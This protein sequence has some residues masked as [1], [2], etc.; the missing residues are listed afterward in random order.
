MGSSSGSVSAAEVNRKM[1]S[2]GTASSGSASSGGASS[3]SA[4]NNRLELSHQINTNSR[5]IYGSICYAAA[6]VFGSSNSNNT[7]LPA[8]AEGSGA[9]STD[10]HAVSFPAAGAEIAASLG[11]SS[12]S[13]CCKPR[14]STAAVYKAAGGSNSRRQQQ[15]EA[16]TAGGSSSRRQLWYARCASAPSKALTSCTEAPAG[17]SAAT[18]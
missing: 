7:T 5:S 17:E 18:L 9:R 15:P 1:R 2:S 3:N 16:A 12:T 13:R 14:D 8:A 4:G 10:G 11:S 6:V